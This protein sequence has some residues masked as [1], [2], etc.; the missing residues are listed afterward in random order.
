MGDYWAMKGREKSYWRL[1]ILCILVPCM[2]SEKVNRW[3]PIATSSAGGGG[4]GGGVV[5]QNSGAGLCGGEQI[6]RVKERCGGKHP[7]LVSRM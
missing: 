1:V 3:L 2:T 4:G 6:K 7:V 5:G